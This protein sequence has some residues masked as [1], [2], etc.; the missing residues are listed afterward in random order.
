[1]NK[2]SLALLMSWFA[3]QATGAE[4][5]WMT[6]LPAAQK[7]AAEEKKLVLIDFTGS[8]WC[9]PCKALHKNVFSSTE[10]DEFAKANLVLVEIDFPRKKEQSDELKKANRALA[11]QYEIKG[12]PTV[13]VLDGSGKQLSKEVG[14]SGLAGKDYVAKLKK[15][16]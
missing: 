2:F 6:D 14:Y 5:Q 15:L 7:K 8:D 12:Y 1:M 10:F 3:F 13:V 9:P 11:T 4:L 16:K